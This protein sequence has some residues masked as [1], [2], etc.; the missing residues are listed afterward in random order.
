VGQRLQRRFGLA[1]PLVLVTGETAPERLQRVRASGVPVLF[2]PV[3]AATLLRMLG[4]F[5]PG[6][7]TQP[8]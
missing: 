1:A 2:K 5:M 4:D 8:A 6:L 3:S 7:A